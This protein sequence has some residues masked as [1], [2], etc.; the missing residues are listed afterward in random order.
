[1]RAMATAAAGLFAYNAARILN[2]RPQAVV[3]NF[4][5]GALWLG[6]A[7]LSLLIV[8]WPDSTPRVSLR[9]MWGALVS[10]WRAHWWEL[11]LFTLLFGFGVFMR[12]YEFGGSLPP[13]NGLCCE[14][15]I[16]GG[17]A[18]R[19][20]QGERPLLYP[21]VRWGSAAG[22]LIFGETTLGL[23]FFFVVMGIATLVPFYLLVL[24][25]YAAAWWPS[26]SSRQTSEG[27]IYAVLFAFLLVWG[28]KRKQPLAFFGLGVLAALLS[29][30]YDA[31][32]PIPY[33][34]L[35][36]VAAAAAWTLFVPLPDRLRDILVRARSIARVAWRPA[37]VFFLAAGIVLVPMI[38]GTHQGYDLYLTSVHRQQSDRGGSLF[39]EDWPRQASWALQIFFPFGSKQYRSEPPLDLAGISLLD[40]LTST[41]AL[42]G[43]V[44][45]AFFFWRSYRSFFLAW[46]GLNMLTGAL[47]LQNFSPWKFISLV[48]VVLVLAAFFLDD[49]WT[50]A[51]RLWQRRGAIALAALFIVGMAFSFWWNA[52]TL[53]NRVATEDKVRIAYASERG[54]MYSFC[55][56]LRDRGDDNFSYAFKTAI[57]VL[58][59]ARPRDTFEQQRGAWGDFIWVCHDLQGEALPAPE[60]A[61]P[62]RDPPPGRTTLVFAGSLRPIEEVLRDLRLAYPDLGEPDRQILGP[63]ES[64]TIWAYEFE[65]GRDLARTGLWSTYRSLDDAGSCAK[66]LLEEGASARVIAVHS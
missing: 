30:E 13:A 63:D 66:S 22:F 48:P 6:L 49:V 20:L 19:A 24:A 57:P 23:R 51:T 54:R 61:W 21:L 43:V 32:R 4:D 59:F 31:F 2:E 27:T 10:F 52:D 47:L 14:E 58:G 29:Y 36:F 8:A 35:G 50:L 9:A 39:V 3:R 45:G 25:L 62:L 38:V 16:N 64:W 55:R 7:L 5:E 11:A 42:V 34:A 37:L 44:A 18:Y 12:V 40:P 60:E 33:V 53:F 41:L 46:F 1:M 56:Y 17:V 65:D 28:L 26:L 15:H